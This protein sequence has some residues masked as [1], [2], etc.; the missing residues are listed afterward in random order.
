MVSPWHP[1]RTGHSGIGESF[2]KLFI[3]IACRFSA[4][5][6]EHSPVDGRQMGPLAE[7]RVEGRNIAESDKQLGMAGDVVEIKERQQP[8]RPIAATHAENPVYGGICKKFVDILCPHV[9]GPGQ[10][11]PAFLHRTAAPCPE[12]QRME[13]RQS[14]LKTCFI[15]WCRRGDDSQCIASLQ[16]PA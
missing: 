4:E 6:G 2:C 13:E 12:A 11:S 10:V 8:G 7:G 1:D 5:S 15:E 16:G 9:V 3:R 14:R